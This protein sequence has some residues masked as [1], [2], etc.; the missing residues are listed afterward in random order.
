MN[1]QKLD[2]LLTKER[3]DEFIELINKRNNSKIKGYLTDIIENQMKEFE[4]ATTL[5][6]LTDPQWPLT[7]AYRDGGKYYLQQLLDLFKEK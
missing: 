7:R 5:R 1:K 4:R 6:D 2:R 3:A